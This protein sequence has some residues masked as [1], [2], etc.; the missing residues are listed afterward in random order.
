MNNAMSNVYVGMPISEFNQA[1]PKKETVSLKE[2]VTIYKVSKR[3]WYDSDGSGSD[4]RYFYFADGKLFQ[5][6]KGE[7]A[8]DQRIRIDTN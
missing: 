2:G 4:Y 3:V 1:F 8:V 5:V 7:R 6:D